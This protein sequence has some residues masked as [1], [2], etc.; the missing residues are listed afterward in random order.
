MQIIHSIADLKDTLP[1]N[2]SIG[3]V[4]TMG[5]LHRGHLSLIE[6]SVKNNDITVVSIFVNP[7]QFLANEDLDKYPK[8]EQSDIKICQLAK[9]DYL[10]MPDISTMYQ[11]DEITIKAPK[12]KGFILEGERRAGHFDGMLQIVLKLLNLVNPT[13]SYFGKKDAQQLYLINQMK[14]NF[15]LKTNIVACDIIREDDGLAMSSR[16]VYLD[17]TQRKAAT[18]ISSALNKAS[19]LI[20]QNQLSVN[21]I[22][23]TINDYLKQSDIIKIEYIYIINRDFDMIKDVEL[24][25]SIILIA[26][27]IG[28]T[29]LIDNIWI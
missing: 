19:N 11:E 4:P 15:Y 2:R 12:I 10:F 6:Q 17:T 14:K 22:I 13:N 3:F 29:R 24:N 23:N 18:M 1:Q 21:I 27:K 5:A 9:V 16:N 20:K 26:V 25:N 7:T 8:Q 28:N